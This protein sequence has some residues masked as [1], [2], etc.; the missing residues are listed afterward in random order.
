MR[1]WHE[2]IAVTQ[3]ILIELLRRGRSLIFWTIFPISVLILSGFI[4][5]ERAEL[6]LEQAF[7]YAAP[8]TLVGAALFFSCLGGSVA[9]VVAER[10]QQT[11]K[12]LFISPLSGT[13]YFLGIFLA[14]SCIGLGQTLLI[15]TIAAFWGASFNGSIILGLTIIVLS[16]VAYV[17]LGF[18][19]GTQLAR[20]IEDVNALVA[21]FGVP[22]LILGGAFLPAS[23]FPQGLINI[24]RFN[25]IYH[26]NEA[27]VQVSS[28]GADI[29]VITSHFW[30][31]FVFAVV[32]VMGGW[33]SYR[34]MLIV[35][36]RL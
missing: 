7:G 19:L 27:L 16:I 22:L 36:R 4:L 25:P 9:T 30:F 15:Y 20:R 11:L 3:R 26:M 29:N 10:E 34:R 33:L 8:S 14:H 5:A 21:A 18:I 28:L 6:P 13:S 31:L 32:M 2:T 35:E 24:A 17:G 12:R 23:L 1:Y